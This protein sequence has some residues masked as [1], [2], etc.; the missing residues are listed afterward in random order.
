MKEKPKLDT[1]KVVL[2]P[3][4]GTIVSLNVKVGD[5][6]AEGAELAVVEAMKMQNVLKAPR[7]GKIEKIN[8]TAGQSVAADEILIEFATVRL[9]QLNGG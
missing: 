9:Q 7:A 2:S 6:V 8:V 1:S 5:T 3:M 4:P